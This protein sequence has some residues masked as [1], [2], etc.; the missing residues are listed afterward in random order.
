MAFS[1]AAA[2]LV[3]VTLIASYWPAR[4]VSR[5]DPLITLRE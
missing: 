3:L 2:V 1:L 5:V 4:R